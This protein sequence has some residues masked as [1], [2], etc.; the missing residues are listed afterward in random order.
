MNQTLY[1]TCICGRA[2]EFKPGEK[3]TFCKTPGCGVVL[4]R[5]PEGYRA[6]GFFTISFT[7]IF[8]AEVKQKLN[9]YQ[10]YM[11]W[12]NAKKRSVV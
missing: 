5:G 2:M 12:R 4:E 6:L 1:P 8:T 11:T 7:P 3:K 9:H 10:R